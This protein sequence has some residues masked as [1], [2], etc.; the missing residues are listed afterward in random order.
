MQPGFN[1]LHPSSRRVS[2]AS[3]HELLQEHVYFA[4]NSDI[5]PTKSSGNN[6]DAL[7]TFRKPASSLEEVSQSIKKSDELDE[8]RLVERNPRMQRFFNYFKVALIGLGGL[9]GMGQIDTASQFT[10]KAQE[11]QVKANDLS[12]QLTKMEYQRPW[13]QAIDQKAAAE[14]RKLNTDYRNTQYQIGEFKDGAA[15]HSV[16]A[17]LAFAA[18]GVFGLFAA[19]GLMGAL[20]TFASKRLLKRGKLYL[21]ERDANL[22]EITS[23]KAQIKNNCMDLALLRA[24]ARERFPEVEQLFK[25]LYGE[26]LDFSR[27]QDSG[28]ERDLLVQQFVNQ[29]HLKLVPG[30]DNQTVESVEFYKQVKNASEAAVKNSHFLPEMDLLAKFLPEVDT[31]FFDEKRTYY[32]KSQSAEQIQLE[33][34]HLDAKITEAQMK[35]VNALIASLP[36]EEKFEEALARYTELKQEENRSLKASANGSPV[37]SN[38]KELISIKLEMSRQIIE[39]LEELQ[40]RDSRRI[41]AFR[42]LIAT[43]ESQKLSLSAIQ[44]KLKLF[45]EMDQQLNGSTRMSQ[46]PEVLERLLAAEQKNPILKD[47]QTELETL[48]TI[49]K[50][51]EEPT[52]ASSTVSK[53]T[54]LIT[55]GTP[56]K[57]ASKTSGS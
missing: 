33:I 45:A 8:K 6:K 47:I 43:Y 11:A 57:E 19:G 48:E 38:G 39:H 36:A 14:Y 52:E 21:Q 12:K 22:P 31:Y 44:N 20:G 55:E 18:T 42:S 3:S 49:K 25:T 17:G 46:D 13:G 41:K 32:G 27:L 5:P 35:L 50:L 51:M 15:V 54:A 7:E 1:V 23:L 16:L 28:S 53:Q 40:V 10:Q 2:K 56:A 9:V 30:S 29:V 4:G 26:N 37:A 24:K 34:T